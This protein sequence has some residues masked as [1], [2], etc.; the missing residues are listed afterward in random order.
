MS[1]HVCPWWLGYLLLLPLRR[2]RHDPKKIFAAYVR[3]GMTVLEP[4]PGMGFF[5]LDLLRMVGDSGRVVAVDVQPR[6]LERL[7]RRAEK[8][9]LIGRLDARLAGAASLGIDDLAGKVDFTVA[10]FV[11]HE[12]PEG[13]PFFREAAA[14]TRSGAPLLLVEPKGH[15]KE[16]EFRREVANALAAGFLVADRPRIGGTRSVL[17]RKA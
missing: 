6:M 7:K 13:H 8:A 14:A 10:M 9:G 4:G 11:V 12:L 2:W 15:V 3:D 1:K 16:Q 17:L 5:T